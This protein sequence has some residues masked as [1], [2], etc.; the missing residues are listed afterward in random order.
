MDLVE[1][2]EDKKEDIESLKVL[3]RELEPQLSK[4]YILTLIGPRRAGKSFFIYH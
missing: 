4:Q 1:Y 3:P 2:L